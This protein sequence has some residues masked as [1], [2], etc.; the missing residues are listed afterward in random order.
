MHSQLV[1]DASKLHQQSE[2]LASAFVDGMPLEVEGSTPNVRRPT[3]LGTSCFTFQEMADSFPVT[4]PPQS[5]ST[6]LSTQRGVQDADALFTK[7]YREMRTEYH[8]LNLIAERWANGT[9]QW[10]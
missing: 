10:E 9:V 5:S 2:T 3:S 6:S 4:A 7:R 8:K 1:H